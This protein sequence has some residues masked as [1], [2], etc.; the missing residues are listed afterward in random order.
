M[1]DAAQ[2]ELLLDKRGVF[3]ASLIDASGQSYEPCIITG[4]Y[5]QNRLENKKKFR[6]P[7]DCFSYPRGRSDGRQ[8]RTQQIPD[9]RQDQPVGST[10]RC[11]GLYLE[12][13]QKRPGYGSVMQKEE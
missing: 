3:E 7:G 9:H 1:D 8:R 11:P 5:E 13:G 10:S 4:H 6:L 12:M 2:R